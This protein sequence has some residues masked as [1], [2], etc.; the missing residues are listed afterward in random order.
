[1]SKLS[2]TD[3]DTRPDTP[4]PRLTNVELT[5]FDDHRDSTAPLRR[6]FTSRYAVAFRANVAN[7][8]TAYTPAGPT[9][10]F[11]GSATRSAMPSL[12]KY[13]LLKFIRVPAPDTAF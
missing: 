3:I 9:A 13:T 2:P 1:M 8:Y 11:C 7:A 5:A 6:M 10:S 4:T 12:S